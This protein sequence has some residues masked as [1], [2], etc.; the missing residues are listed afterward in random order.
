MILDRRVQR[1]AKWLTRDYPG[2]YN[3]IPLDVLN[4]QDPDK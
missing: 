4:V 2:W 3:T 1:G